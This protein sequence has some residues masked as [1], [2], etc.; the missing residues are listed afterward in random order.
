MRLETS[1]DLAASKSS[2]LK[3]EDDYRKRYISVANIFSFDP[4]ANINLQKKLTDGEITNILKRKKKELKKWSEPPK[5]M[6]LKIFSHKVHTQLYE[7]Y[8]KTGV[9]TIPFEIIIFDTTNLEVE[10]KQQ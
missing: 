9:M 6:D 2:S 8:P 5:G 1:Y 3:I 4:T 7:F 10:C